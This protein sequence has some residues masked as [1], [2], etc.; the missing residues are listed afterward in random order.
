MWPTQL[1]PLPVFGNMSVVVE[2][3]LHRQLSAHR[4]TAKQYNQCGAAARLQRFSG[5]KD[6]TISLPLLTVCGLAL[7]GN[8]KPFLGFSSNKGGCWLC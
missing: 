8:D 2:L 3:S 5:S 7:V 1:Q 4:V 6:D